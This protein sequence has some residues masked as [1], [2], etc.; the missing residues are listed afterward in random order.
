MSDI[1]NK[2]GPK[3]TA[4]VKRTEQ[5]SCYITKPDLDYLD[6][7]A[8]NLGAKSRSQLLTAIVER[9]I[10]GGFSPMAFVKVGFQIQRKADEMGVPQRGLY[11]GIRPLPPLFDD[12]EPTPEEL[13]PVVAEINHALA[14]A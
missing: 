10:I 3:P 8:Q 5:L 11:F 2:R 12:A 6:T 14:N 4:A 1:P 9:L 13:R 7:L